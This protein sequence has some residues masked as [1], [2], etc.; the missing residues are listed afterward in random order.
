MPGVGKSA[1]GRCLGN[2][3]GRPTLLLDVGSLLGSLV[4]Q[5]EQNLRQALR[6]ADAMSPAVLFCDEVEKAL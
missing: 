6:I 3:T 4:G 2:E 5:S 1:F